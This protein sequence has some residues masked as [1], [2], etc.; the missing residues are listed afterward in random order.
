M[1]HLETDALAISRSFD[2]MPEDAKLLASRWMKGYRDQQF[3]LGEPLFPSQER[4]LM[5][6]RDTLRSLYTGGLEAVPVE[7]SPWSQDPDFERATTANVQFL[8]SRYPDYHPDR[9]EYFLA[10]YGLQKFQDPDLDDKA[11]Y[12]AVQ[13]V[14]KQEVK[15]EGMQIGAA[16]AAYDAVTIGKPMLTALNEWQGVDQGP[17]TQDKLD[18]TPLFMQAYTSFA[19]DLGKLKGTVDWLEKELKLVSKQEDYTPEYVRYLQYGGDIAPDKLPNNRHFDFKPSIQALLAVPRE[20][21]EKVLDALARRQPDAAKDDNA[22]ARL[23]QFFERGVESLLVEGGT[24]LK[25]MALDLITFPGLAPE[26]MPDYDEEDAAEDARQRDY[27]TLRVQLREIGQRLAPIKDVRALSLNFGGAAQSA[28]TTLAAFVPYA[29]PAMIIGQF[30]QEGIAKL[31]QDNPGMD[32][33]TAA[34]IS[35]IAAPIQGLSSVFVSK[36]TFGRTPAFGAFLN[37]PMLTAR[38]LATRFGSRV[39]VGTGGEYVDENLQF[40]TPLFLQEAAAALSQDIPHV[41][42]PARLAELKGMQWEIISTA[43]PLVLIGSGAGSIRDLNNGRSLVRDREALI[44]AGYAPEVAATIRRTVEGGDLR[45]AEAMMREQMDT[46]TPEQ[47]Q[48]AAN[49]YMRR[50]NVQTRAVGQLE[51]NG[52]LATVRPTANG[53][54]VRREQRAVAEFPTFEAADAA[55]WA[56]AR[57]RNLHVHDLYRETIS[58]IERQLKEGQENIIIFSDERMTPETAV[59]RG[60]AKPEQLTRRQAQSRALDEGRLENDTYRQA[61]AEAAAE[62]DPTPAY[63]ILGANSIEHADGVSRAIIRLFKGA[64]PHDLIEE[65][66]EVGVKRATTPEARRDLL[67]D[68]RDA[69]AKIQAAETAAG[70]T[71]TPLFRTQNDAEIE[72]SDL[73]EAFSHLAKSYYSN[74]ASGKHTQRYVQALR[75]AVT[76]SGAFKWISALGSKLGN[77]LKRAEMIRQVQNGPG[78]TPELETLIRQSVG[79]KDRVVSPSAVTPNQKQS[80][81]EAVAQ[82]VEGISG[83]TFSL[84]P[85]LEQTEFNQPA[86]APPVQGIQPI[87]IEDLRGKAAM[88]AGRVWLKQEGKR[89]AASMPS[90]FVLSGQGLGKLARVKLEGGELVNAHFQAI[91]ALPEL[92]A[93]SEVMARTPD[94]EGGDSVAF[95]ERRYAW[96][97]FPDG[98]RRH[99]LMTVRYLLETAEPP[100]MY[101]LEALEVRDASEAFR[102]GMSRGQTT[103]PSAATELDVNLADFMAGVKPEHKEATASE[104]TFSLSRADDLG[105]VSAALDERSAADPQMRPTLLQRGAE[106][107]AAARSAWTAHLEKPATGPNQQSAQEQALRSLDAIHTLLPPEARARLGGFIQ[108]DALATPEARHT[109]IEKRF[110]QLA[111]L[112]PQAAHQSFDTA[113]VAPIRPAGENSP[114]LGA[115]K[116]I[117]EVFGGKSSKIPGATNVDIIAENGIRDSAANLASHFPPESQDV[118][119]ASNPRGIMLNDWLKNAA[120]VLK[121]DGRIVINGTKSNKCIRLPSDA[122]LSA[123]GLEIVEKWIP[124]SEEFKGQTFHRIEGGSIPSASI[125]TCILR[126]KK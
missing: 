1:P 44:A 73:I 23:A 9:H 121:P 46:A 32:Y 92:L 3:E 108:T 66:A 109:E 78:F 117:I 16:Q 49:E 4:A 122:E 102:D 17:Q 88:D 116:K 84:R 103:P 67:A 53:W 69:E 96:A 63:V 41:N 106:H 38:G 43:L 22:A 59:E 71:A 74:E 94:R 39:V 64:T 80:H 7:V 11:F 58:R 118:I 55:R 24:G 91:G 8:Q 61:T 19:S 124:L 120:S 50:L 101:S 99:V 119:V 76:G 27:E 25:N 65:F 34:G 30:R 68:L 114:L 28:P 48:A 13:G 52:T 36:L 57:E 15:V 82:V 123:M 111:S 95:Y 56:D 14:M 105:A 2:S 20:H 77:V 87:G 104:T 45:A 12:G 6:R 18:M 81:L 70:E 54:Q 90:P 125:R 107:L 60:L 5:E 51:L 35:N 115:N 83:V 97:L 47:R 10:D 26:D 85:R 98:Q 113:D 100:R 62:G 37:S 89:L 86:K 72:D 29:G 42:W 93:N 79:L 40:V 21:R 110:T 33:E 126:R 75:Q 31:L 112:L